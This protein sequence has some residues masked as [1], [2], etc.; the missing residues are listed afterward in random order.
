M[1]VV[2]VLLFACPSLQQFKRLLA[3]YI[4][5]E[6]LKSKW[7]CLA[8]NALNV[9]LVCFKCFGI[10]VGVGLN[11]NNVFKLTNL[12]TNL[13]NQLHLTDTILKP[14]QYCLLNTHKVVQVAFY[15]VAAQ[16]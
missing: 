15:P 11:I 13:L 4:P 10:H 12:R 9:Q 1:Q 16:N 3:S 7:L 2:P 14:I 6:A 8:E 5:A